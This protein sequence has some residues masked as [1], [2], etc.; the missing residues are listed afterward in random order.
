MRK[1]THTRSGTRTVTR[2]GT[3]TPH[4]RAAVA[5]AAAGVLTVCL[6][7]AANAATAA[8]AAAQP[9]PHCQEASADSYDKPPPADPGRFGYGVLPATEGVTCLINQ[10]RQRLGLQPLSDSP[11]LREAANKHVTAA[12]AL[13]WWGKDKDPHQN[14]QVPGTGS[15]QIA[16]RIKNAGYCANGTSWEGYE[17]AY[18]GWGGNGTP[19]AA[20]RWWLQSPTHAEIIR[21][22]ALTEFGIAP[23]GGAADPA[24]AGA[25][26]AGTYVVTLGRCEK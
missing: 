8:G 14:P 9:W 16:A 10:E 7:P 6:A 4:V 23:R 17:I 19:R 12:L 22:P 18:N 5:L 11:E 26:G 25:A 13:K 2:A 20:V 1:R 21:N 3:R 15:E 24:G